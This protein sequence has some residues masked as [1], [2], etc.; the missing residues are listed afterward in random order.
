MP[1]KIL[2]VDDEPDIEAMILSVFRKTIN[3]GELEF[4]F[5]GNGEEA[6]SILEKE[7]SIG[8]I[9]TD[10][11][12]PVMDGLTL[13]SKL[14]D[15]GRSYKAVV[16]TA[17][18][19]MSNIRAAM[20]YG[21]SDFI[22]KPIDFVDFVETLNT[23]IE[24]NKKSIDDEELRVNRFVK[25]MLSFSHQE[26]KTIEK[27]D[28]NAIIEEAV[29]LTYTS[30]QKKNPSFNMTIQA[31]YDDNIP[32]LNAYKDDLLCVFSN[33]V[34]NACYTLSEKSKKSPEDF[35]PTLEITTQNE[36]NHV[37]IT[38]RDNG[39]GIAEESIDQIF[40]PFYTSKSARAGTGLSLSVA[41][42][43]I[44]KEHGGTI[45]VRSEPNIK[46]EFVITL[47]FSWLLEEKT[48]TSN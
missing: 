30:Y 34:D 36:A 40:N 44:T 19:D 2:V 3:S 38:I 35:T 20:K 48:E 37:K 5:A 21:A 25:E 45:H 7:P 43:V 10:L 8:V 29:N 9:L 24:E 32:K 15:L 23:L 14:L 26:S 16:V 13:L 42:L 1:T 33:L 41:Y 4:Y 11:N 12:M 28:I 39:I 46:T 27:V 18:E 47:P 31:S 22:T 6:L 17:Y